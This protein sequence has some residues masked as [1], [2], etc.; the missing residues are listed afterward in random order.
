M[1]QRAGERERDREGKGEREREGEEE[2][3]RGR[4]QNGLITW[5]RA[6]G[7][8]PLASPPGGFALLEILA[9]CSLQNLMCRSAADSANLL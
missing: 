9:A 2:G 1:K 5:L 8:P 7:F 6:M 4:D 3:E